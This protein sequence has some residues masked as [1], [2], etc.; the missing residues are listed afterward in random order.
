MNG[1]TDLSFLAATAY[2]KGK[3]VVMRAQFSFTNIKKSNG[4]SAKVPYSY[5]SLPLGTSKN[6]QNKFSHFF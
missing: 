1:H 6:P 3:T 4:K 2:L 5:A